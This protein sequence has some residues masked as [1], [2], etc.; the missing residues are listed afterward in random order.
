MRRRVVNPAMNSIAIGKV[1]ARHGVEGW[2]Q[3]V[4][5]TRIGDE[6]IARIVTAGLACIN[7]QAHAADLLTDRPSARRRPFVEKIQQIFD[8]AKVARAGKSNSDG[9][10]Q[11]KLVH[12]I[13]PK[14]QRATQRGAALVQSFVEVWSTLI[15]RFGSKRGALAVHYG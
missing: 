4:E 8:G 13:P 7:C 14:W 15:L 11:I 5:K 10:G 2:L 9:D 1:V 3:D 12:G 6:C